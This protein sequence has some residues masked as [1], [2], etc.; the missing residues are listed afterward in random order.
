MSMKLVGTAYYARV[1]GR[2]NKSVSETLYLSR[3]IL[4]LLTSKAMVLFYMRGLTHPLCIK[5]PKTRPTGQADRA[6][7][8]G[9]GGLG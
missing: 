3:Y 4:T 8:F 9:S 2:S 6:S 7:A 5:M 1:A